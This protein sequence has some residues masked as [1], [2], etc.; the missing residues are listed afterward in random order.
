MKKITLFFALIATS[1]AFV[2]CENFLFKVPFTPTEIH[3]EYKGRPDWWYI[4]PVKPLWLP[5]K[6]NTGIRARFVAGKFTTNELRTLVSENSCGSLPAFPGRTSIVTN[7]RQ[8][9]AVPT[10]FP[11]PAS[12]EAYPDKL[13]YVYYC[14]SKDMSGLQ[15]DGGGYNGNWISDYPTLN[16]GY[17]N[18]SLQLYFVGLAMEKAGYIEEAI[19]A[20]YRAV[21]LNY[22]FYTYKGKTGVAPVLQDTPC[23][24]YN[25]D[26]TTFWITGTVAYA[27]LVRLVQ[28][29]GKALDIKYVNHKFEAV[30]E[31]SPATW[32]APAY[33]IQ[34]GWFEPYTE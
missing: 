8:W 6:L 11:Y 30:G 9:P 20:Y 12:T 18:Q 16:G 7:G 31:I 10:G 2:S 27:N 32:I 33:D 19:V 4:L 3:D 14:W 28:R 26:G 22:R 1:L 5:N 15:S 23:T 24:I 25:Q 29:Y 21:Q 17:R 13:D 34:V